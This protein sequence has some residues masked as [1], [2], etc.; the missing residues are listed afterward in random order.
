MNRREITPPKNAKPALISLISSCPLDTS[1]LF[2]TV[3]KE[4]TLFC[5]P[6]FIT[7]SRKSSFWQNLRKQISQWKQLQALKQCFSWR[8]FFYSSGVPKEILQGAH[9]ISAQHANINA[10]GP[11]NCTP[12]ETGQ[13]S[14]DPNDEVN[15]TG[16]A[17]LLQGATENLTVVQQWDIV[18]RKYKVAQ[19]C[20]EQLAKLKQ[21]TASDERESLLRT[22]ITAVAEAAE[23][24][25]RMHH[26]E[27][28]KQLQQF[29][30]QQQ[31][32]EQK[33]VV[34]Y[35]SDFLRSTDPNFWYSCFVRLFPRGD[36][37][38]KSVR[39]MTHIPSWRWAKTLLTRADCSLWRCNVEFVACLYNVFLRREQIS[40]V[41]ILMKTRTLSPSQL[42]ELETLTADGLVAHA[43]ASGDVHSVR[44]LLRRKN[45]EAPLRLAFSTMQMIQ[46]RVRGSD[47]EK[48]GLIPQFLAMRVWGGCSSLFFTLNPHD[49]RSPLTMKLLQGPQTHSAH[50]SLDCSD[51][52]G[53]EY[54]KS[55]LADNP[56]RLHQMVAANPLAAT[57]CFHWTVRL[58]LRTLFS[59][60]ATCTLQSHR[61]LVIFSSK[62]H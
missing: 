44:D 38:E 7:I 31:Q 42:G 57:Y 28:Q 26:K 19:L 33:I 32:D 37:Q 34:P 40:A 43:L 2:K 11:A 29:L 24:F 9:A 51:A 41:E 10:A 47:S 18:M 45:L 17:G 12:E 49:I 4:S 36:A 46:R 30:Q 8:V 56:R 23:A 5:R 55:F 58:V 59:C 6:R 16:T 14:L 15:S 22:R 52:E 39:R 60:T 54:M 1:Y 48:D 21:H 13:T 62:F 27:A 25:S 50:F 61:Q 53:E 3:S 20:D 35:E